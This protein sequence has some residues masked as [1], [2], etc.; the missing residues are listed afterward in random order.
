MITKNTVQTKSRQKHKENR[1]LGKWQRLI[2]IFANVAIILGIIV[3]LSQY[4]HITNFNSKQAIS[5][6]NLEKR[7][8]AIEAIDKIYNNDFLKKYAIVISCDSLIN[9]EQKYDLYFLIFLLRYLLC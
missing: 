7:K 5:S 3:S 8:N 6:E 2:S 4:I 1:P 9:N